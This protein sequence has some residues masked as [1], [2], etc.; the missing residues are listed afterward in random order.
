MNDNDRLSKE[1]RNRADQAGGHPISFD[2][3]KRS[4]RKMKWQQRAAAGAVAAVVLAIAVPVG[5]SIA[6]NGSKSP[7]VSNPSPTIGTPS[8]TAT[9]TPQGVKKVD[10]TA[11]VERHSGE[12]QIPT[13]QLGNITA[14]N[15][16]QVPVDVALV[17]FAPVGDGFIGLG[18]DD[19]GNWFVYTIDAA[20]KVTEKVAAGGYSLGVSP[21][22]TQVAYSTADGKIFVVWDGG[23]RELRT[24]GARQIDVVAVRGSGACVDPDTEAGNGC[25]VFWNDGEKAMYSS[26]HGIV[27]QVAGGFRSAVGLSPEGDVAGFVSVSD[28]GSCSAVTTQDGKQLWKTCDY[29]LGRFSPDGR[30]VIGRPAYLD[31]IGDSMVAVLD[32]KTGVPLVEYDTADNAFINN[33]VWETDGTL[34]TMLYDEGWALLR[35]GVD[36]EFANSSTGRIPGEAE[37]P[38][39]FFVAR[40]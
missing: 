35:L 27:D 3:V 32:A 24:N 16:D 33:T 30:Y 2:D 20:G 26:E 39:V 6:N 36:G 18:G 4:A 37:S 10:L 5:L 31:G 21:D 1:L 25:T 17:S 38:P 29:S 7:P 14:T 28:D 40:P 11:N 34:L 15:G 9:K 22:G 19:Q 8:P 12:P 13:I 23:R